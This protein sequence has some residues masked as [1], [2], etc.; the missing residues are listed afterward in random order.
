MI[1]NGPDH[2]RY[3][4]NKTKLL[5]FIGQCIDELDIGSNALVGD[6]F[7]GTTS[8]ARYLKNRGFQVYA[9]DWLY[10]SYALAVANIEL[11]ES[12]YFSNLKSL[13]SVRQV[14]DHLNS[15]DGAHGFISE[16]YSPAGHEKRQY[17]S[18]ENAGKIDSIRTEIESWYEDSL[19]STPEKCYLL[20]CLI[21]AISK[22]SNTSGTYGSYLKKWD[23]RANNKIHLNE[24]EIHNNEQNNKSFNNDAVDFVQQQKFDFVYLDPPY[25]SRQYASNYFLLELIAEGWFG[26]RQPDIYGYTGMRP[27]GHQKSLFSR[28]S[29][30]NSALD[31]L[32]SNI[33]A[34]YAL[35]SYNNEGLI[36]PDEI[37]RILRKY[38]ETNI[39]EFVHRRYKSAGKNDER[40]TK[41]LIYI[42]R[43]D[44]G[45]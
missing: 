8:V 41:E 9:N 5:S 44:S 17:F 19:I 26:E 34:K 3:Y 27:Y 28:K 14:L 38:G 11:N 20:A 43:L 10:F 6:V 23:K 35:L 32:M 13:K 25:N 29:T 37:L 1:N 30:A 18:A 7:T 22:V 42:T 39:K 33:K 2:I 21:Y 40:K 24:I 12:P 16:S 15:L 4:G 31:T 45:R 36:A